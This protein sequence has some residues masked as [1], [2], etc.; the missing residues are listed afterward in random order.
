MSTA[1][2]KIGALGFSSTHSKNYDSQTINFLAQITGLAALAVEN[3]LLKEA[4]AGEEEQLRGLTAASIQLSERSASDYAALREERARLEAILEINV[5][6]AGTRLDMKQIFPAISRS[7]GK[8]V[9]HDTAVINLW[10]EDLCSYLVFA[11]SNR[12][13][14]EFAPAGLVLPSQNA[15]TTQV[16][17][18][19]PDG[20]V[21]QRAEL[22]AVAPQFEVVQSALNAGIVGWC[23]VPM[24]TPSHLVGVLYL[25]S[26]IQNAFTEKHLD[27]VRQV[28]PALGIFLENAVTHEGLKREK[29]RLQMLL[30][31]STALTRSLNS[32][33]LFHD[34]SERIRRVVNQEYTHLALYDQAMSVLRIH[35]L[36]FPECYGH[37]KVGSTAPLADIPDGTVFRERKA[38]LFSRS[39]FEQI[40]SECMQ[41]LLAEDIRSF[42]CFPLTSGERVLGTLAVG[43]RKDDAFSQF[44][45]DVLEQVA[46]Q[47][48]VAV[49][50]Y[51]MFGEIASLKDRLTKEKV[52]LEQEIRDALNFEEIVGQSPALM[53]V[54]D[55]VKTVA[56]SDASVLILGE[57]GT[58]KELV[59]RAIH[60][61][62]KRQAG[63]FV[64][65]NCAAIPTGLLESELFGHEKGAF[66]GAIS[67]KIGRLE[68]ADK[69]TL[70]L[71]EAGEIPL[72]IQPKLLRVLQDHEF[73]R[74]GGTRTIRVDVRI[75]AATNRDLN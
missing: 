26:R 24:R 62:S 33:E 46:P 30:E 60:R 70:L 56:P 4:I 32:K 1:R 14:S 12:E 8:A 21:V 36:D 22:E 34:I 65:L 7:L 20:A 18:M 51:R 73:E 50:N 23:V 9:P 3:S 69:G 53:R 64:K 29:D 16:L 27:L 6:L 61:L 48:A 49:D 43:S 57:T 71:D 41:H 15:F 45:L 37:L 39:D 67:Q 47:V 5:A 17:D 54:L 52:Y 31:I 74:L 44:Q 2:R 42:Y 13:G 72:E 68:L 10:N 25:G 28:A 38:R 63:N 58:G 66:T 40:K 35:A 55:Q 19:H 11:K 75:V 59:A